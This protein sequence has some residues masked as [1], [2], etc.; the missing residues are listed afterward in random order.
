MKE[1]LLSIISSNHNFAIPLIAIMVI[2]GSLKALKGFLDFHYEYY[3][4]KHLKRVLEIQPLVKNS[5]PYYKFA[6]SVIDMEAFKIASGVRTSK[7]KALALIC[8]YEK[9]LLPITCIK[10]MAR[11]IST[12]NNESIVVT[13]SKTDKV[14]AAF[15]LL[16]STATLAYGIIVYIA[17]ILEGYEGLIIGSLLILVFIIAT[18]IFSED[19]RRYK[20]A[21]RLQISL[22]EA[23]LSIS[24]VTDGAT[25]TTLKAASES[26]IHEG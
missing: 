7:D 26:K 8:L 5:E 15:S 16:L 24:K 1:Q 25:D 21:K 22:K 2:S 11:Y 20:Q 23:P 13:L 4:R 10:P 19:V 17:L 6:Q 3:T 18:R 14:L 12:D 9:N